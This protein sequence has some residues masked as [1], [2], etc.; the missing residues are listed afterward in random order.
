MNIET[1]TTMEESLPD[2]ELDH[3]NDDQSESSSSSSW[4]SSDGPSMDFLLNR[5]EEHLI[6]QCEDD[7]PV[8]SSSPSHLRPGVSS[9]QRAIGVERTL[10]TGRIQLGESLN[11]KDLCV[12]AP[13]PQTRDRSAST[14]PSH[15][16]TSSN[17]QT[18]EYKVENTLV[19]PKPQYARPRRLLAR[20]G[21][22]FVWVSMPGDIQLIDQESRY[23]YLYFDGFKQ[24]PT[25]R[26]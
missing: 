14:S 18:L 13:T 26:P 15:T 3:K 7:R 8:T 5:Q 12:N 11:L 23:V 17:S 16:E 19:L 25:T 4:S 20:D 24:Y 1:D 6:S 9:P 10:R 22:P 2:M 21:T